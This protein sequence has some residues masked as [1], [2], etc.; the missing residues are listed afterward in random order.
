MLREGW[1]DTQITRT[2]AQNHLLCCR[3][4]R[5]ESEKARK[6]PSK[7]ERTQREHREV[8]MQNCRR[9]DEMQRV[10]FARFGQWKLGMLA[11]FVG[12]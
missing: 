6:Q 9:C 4:R 7:K 8:T 12:S 11:L 3:E 5:R 1:A 10:R 2:A